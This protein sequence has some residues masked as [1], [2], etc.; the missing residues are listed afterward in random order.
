[1][2]VEGKNVALSYRNHRE[3]WWYYSEVHVVGGIR[4]GLDVKKCIGQ[5]RIYVQE[6]VIWGNNWY[7]GQ[8]G[9]KE[10]SLNWSALKVKFLVLGFEVAQETWPPHYFPNKKCCR[11]RGAMSL[12]LSMLEALHRRSLG[13]S[14]NPSCWLFHLIANY[15]AHFSKILD[16]FTSSQKPWIGPNCGLALGGSIA[17]ELQN[18]AILSVES[19]VLDPR[20]CWG[21]DNSAPFSCQISLVSTQ[22]NTLY[23]WNQNFK[24]VSNL[25]SSKVRGVVWICQFLS[26]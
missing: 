24:F 19:N 5:S 4:V 20:R 1:M 8:D 6:N 13:C 3:K 23:E 12:F 16:G 21:G 15:I 9:G 7:D 18:R 25:E 26:V 11:V 22:G 2:D 10:N 14:V 17:K